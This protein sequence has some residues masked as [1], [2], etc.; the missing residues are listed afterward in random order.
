MHKN[1]FQV[2]LYEDGRISIS[3][4]TVMSFNARVIGLSS[5]EGR[6]AGEI[7]VTDFSENVMTCADESSSSSIVRSRYDG[8]SE[9]TS[10]TTDGHIDDDDSSDSVDKRWSSFWDEFMS[11]SDDTDEM[12]PPS[13][14]I[15]SQ[16]R[17]QQLYE[18]IQDTLNA[19]SN[20]DSS[21]GQ[22]WYIS[23]GRPAADALSP[24]PSPY[25]SAYGEPASR[26]SQASPYSSQP[27]AGNEDA[28]EDG[29]GSFWSFLST[30]RPPRGRKL[31]LT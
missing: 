11:G 14:P 31:L 13:P 28:A 6:P 17:S 7:E 26:P 1:S 16:V 21:H 8:S 4:L 20:E 24:P 15:A 23:A 3:Y 18:R 9:T 12:P 10:E 19:L 22:P 29:W 27:S 5:G 2:T 30:S 25:E